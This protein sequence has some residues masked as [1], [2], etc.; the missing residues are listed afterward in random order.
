MTADVERERND[1]RKERLDRLLSGHSGRSP[2]IAKRG[3]DLIPVGQ[4]VDRELNIG[5]IEFQ[6]VNK[7]P[8]RYSR[9]EFARVARH[10]ARA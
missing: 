9:Y 3:D 8:P 4:F 5:L 2:A 10:G 7:A 1:G 6:I